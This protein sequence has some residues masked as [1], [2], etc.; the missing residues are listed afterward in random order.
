[1]T[2]M[3]NEKN[4]PIPNVFTRENYKGF[5]DQLTQKDEHVYNILNRFG[6]P[7][8]WER[9]KG[10][11]GLVRIILEQQ[12]SLAS[13]LSVYKKLKKI[14]SIVSPQNMINMADTDLK[15]CGFSRQKTAYVKNLAHE[16]LEKDLDLEQLSHKTDGEVRQFKYLFSLIFCK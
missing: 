3:K 7:P 6:Y 9:E 13:A 5:C 12:V 10:F 8:L 14:T 16:I 11:K 4:I 15:L 2:R 1:M